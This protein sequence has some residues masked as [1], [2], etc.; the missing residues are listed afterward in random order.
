MLFIQKA[1]ILKSSMF[2]LSLCYFTV[3]LCDFYFPFRFMLTLYYIN[4][5]AFSVILINIPVVHYSSFPLPVLWLRE[6]TAI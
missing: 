6:L 1:A 4:L 5:F 3:D 2:V